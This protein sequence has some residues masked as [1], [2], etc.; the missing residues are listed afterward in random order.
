[1]SG[2]IVTSIGAIVSAVGS[3]TALSACSQPPRLRAQKTS[4]GWSGPQNTGS[5]R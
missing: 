5:G 3:R 1:V 4:A 2:P